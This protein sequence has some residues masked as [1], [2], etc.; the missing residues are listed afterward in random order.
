MYGV[1]AGVWILM[2]S[3]RARLSRLCGHAPYT[4]LN[5]S[6]ML[7]F[8][9]NASPE[10]A[11]C[12]ISPEQHHQ[13]GEDGPHVTAADTVPEMNESLAKPCRCEKY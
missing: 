3:V 11:A 2:A 5:V 13:L 8:D 4:L 10:S 9:V 1:T 6:I 12:N 7:A